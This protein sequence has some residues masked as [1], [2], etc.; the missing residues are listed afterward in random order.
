LV[1]FEPENKQAKKELDELLKL[2]KSEKALAQNN[3]QKI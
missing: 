3:N 2:K 1:K